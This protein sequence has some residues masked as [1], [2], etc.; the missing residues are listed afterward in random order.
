MSS[1]ITRTPPAPLPEPAPPAPTPRAKL[2]PLWVRILEPIASLRITV[3]LF[4]FS[5]GLVFFGTL[6]QVDEGIWFVVGK[7]FRSAFV[8]VPFQI[9]FPRPT[10]DGGGLAVGGAFPFPGGWLLGGLL[11]V[12]LLAAHA[13]RFKVSWKRS[14]ILL[15]HAGLIVMM[16]SELIT[17][18]MAN[19]GLMRIRQGGASN[20]VED[21]HN[22]ELALVRADGNKDDVVVVPAS[23]L[24]S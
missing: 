24:E 20:F 19:E 10:P 18:L 9:F 23:L 11:L 16:L 2:K 3:V 6:A 12:N 5:L 13:I 22:A 21:V 15:I 8:W 4:A 14:G 7:Y 17:G 1:A